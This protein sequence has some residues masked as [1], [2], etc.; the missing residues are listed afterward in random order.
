MDSHLP[1]QAVYNEEIH[2]DKYD[3]VCPSIM[4]MLDVMPK[5]IETEDLEYYLFYDF[6]DDKVYYTSDNCWSCETDILLESFWE[7]PQ[8]ALAEM[9]LWLV[10]NWHINFNEAK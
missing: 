5:S 7:N 4:E 8:N 6:N 9:I 1:C 2:S 10:D 3:Y